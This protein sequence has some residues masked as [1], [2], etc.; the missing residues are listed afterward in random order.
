LK[1][2]KKKKN[3]FEKFEFLFSGTRYSAGRGGNAHSSSNMLNL[4]ITHGLIIIFI[5]QSN[6]NLR[7][8]NNEI[9][10]Y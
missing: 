10:K 4:N 3:V 5:A 2:F 1:K 8:K 7:K 6:N 9:K